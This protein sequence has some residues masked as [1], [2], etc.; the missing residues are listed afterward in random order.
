MGY[1]RRAP[2]QGLHGRGQAS[3][4]LVII[5]RI[6]NI[7]LAIVLGLRDQIDALEALHEIAARPLAFGAAAIGVTAPVEIDIGEV[8]AR[9][10]APFVHQGL[11]ARAVG[12]RLGA[13]YPIRR[14]ALGDLAIYAA[15]L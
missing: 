10:P 4:E 12:T 6:Q 1:P 15:G 5:V 11:Q 9:A 2:A 3:H 13:E 8:G 7:V 14:P